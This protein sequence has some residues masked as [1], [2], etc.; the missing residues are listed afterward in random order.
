[1]GFKRELITKLK[2]RTDFTRAGG[3]LPRRAAAG[4]VTASSGPARRGGEAA[5]EGRTELY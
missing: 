5:T 4:K 2:S 1:M 3:D